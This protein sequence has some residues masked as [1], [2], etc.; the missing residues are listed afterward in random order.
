LS[1]DEGNVDETTAM[2]ASRLSGY[3]TT[4]ADLDGG[5][6][7]RIRKSAYARSHS[8]VLEH[9][10]QEGPVEGERDE[11]APEEAAEQRPSWWEKAVG[12]FR[13]VELENKGSVARDHLAL[14]KDH[15]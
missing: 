9:P 10:T 2:L 13:S 3:Q 4:R 5:S 11:G 8:S 1:F 14:G 15:T 7:P 6:G 12:P